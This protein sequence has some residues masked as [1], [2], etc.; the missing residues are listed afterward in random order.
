MRVT[1]VRSDRVLF[2]GLDADHNRL[3]EP[4]QA[5]GGARGEARDLPGVAR[6]RCTQLGD[7]GGGQG[8]NIDISD[9][10]G[11]LL[12]RLFSK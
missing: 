8:E 3:L 10:D 1:E 11:H 6:L 9:E 4:S 12:F 2:L 7:D 5:R